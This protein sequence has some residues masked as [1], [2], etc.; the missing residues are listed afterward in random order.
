MQPSLGERRLGRRAVHDDGLQVMSPHEPLSVQAVYTDAVDV[1]GPRDDAGGVE[2]E[3]PGNTDLQRDRA[4]PSIAFRGEA[5]K[6]CSAA[7]T[8]PKY[9]ERKGRKYGKMNRHPEIT[10]SYDLFIKHRI[11][12]KN[13]MTITRAERVVGC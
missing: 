4:I 2:N 6:L 12:V 5:I 1:H 8:C 7:I 10:F 11:Q 3:V 13:G 9:S